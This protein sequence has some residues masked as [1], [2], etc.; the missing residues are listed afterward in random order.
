MFIVVTMVTI[1]ASNLNFQFF[2]LLLYDEFSKE[3]SG[4][5]FKLQKFAFLKNI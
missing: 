4:N 2:D 5:A 1:Y 3:D